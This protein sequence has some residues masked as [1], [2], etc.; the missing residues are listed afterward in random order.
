MSE[1]NATGSQKLKAAEADMHLTLNQ[2][3][4]SEALRYRQEAAPVA[5]AASWKSSIL[6]TSGLSAASMYRPAI[7]SLAL[8]PT[9]F[10]CVQQRSNGVE[11]LQLGMG[12]TGLSKRKFWKYTCSRLVGMRHGTWESI[13]ALSGFKLRGLAC[14]S[15]P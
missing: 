12:A 8:E 1:H 7:I 2:P 11:L 14:S 3:E 13:A 6:A 15:L 5:C 4:V 9:T 10:K